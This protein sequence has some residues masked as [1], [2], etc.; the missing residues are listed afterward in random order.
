MRSTQRPRPDTSVRT[1]KLFDTKPTQRA[2]YPW[3]IQPL[4]KQSLTLFARGI[5]P[6]TDKGRSRGLR[7]VRWGPTLAIAP[8]SVAV[9]HFA[10]AA[11]HGLSHK[12]WRNRR[13]IGFHREH[14]AVPMAAKPV[15]AEPTQS[16]EL[17]SLATS[18]LFPTRKF[19]Q[20]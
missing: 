12:P 5:S 13:K 17:S 14:G 4:L 8:R 6:D 2:P 9:A 11:L 16:R 18:L 15:D 19:R 20:C 7:Y 3:R 1:G 10:Y